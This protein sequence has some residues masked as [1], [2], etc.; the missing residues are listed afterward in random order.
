MMKK[1][2]WI[3]I[4]VG[5]KFLKIGLRYRIQ[6]E[7]R[8]W[9]QPFIAT[10][11][12]NRNDWV[13][14]YV[15]NKKVLH[16]GFADAPFTE[17]R[18]HDDT[19]LHTHLKKAAQFIFGI[20]TNMNAVHSYSKFTGDTEVKSIGIEDMH[21][22]ELADYDIFLI[23]EVLEH[24]ESPLIL[25]EDLKNKLISG[26]QL[27]VT[28]PNYISFDSLSAVLHETESVHADHHWYFS[29]YTLA[30]KFSPEFWRQEKL[31]FGL[32]GKKKP[33]FIQK[34]FPAIADCIVIVLSKK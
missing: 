18:I 27:I 23:G 26:Q 7:G 6:G 34:D 17:E 13:L 29:P 4:W 31:I 11:I 33:N 21:A 25:I 16:I 12:I 20:D 22:Q 1:I 19:L 15:R 5:L 3:F 9:L 28:V 8:L 24:V 14:N 2:K 30:K 10:G 32:Y